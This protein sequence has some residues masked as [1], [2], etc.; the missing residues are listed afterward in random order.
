MTIQL[1]KLQKWYRYI[2]TDANLVVKSE[3]EMESVRQEIEAV[4]SV[5]YV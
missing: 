3:F 2:E 5:I 1:Q 4:L